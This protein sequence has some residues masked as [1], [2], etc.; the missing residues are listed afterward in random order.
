MKSIVKSIFAGGAMMA[1][2]TAS[3]VPVISINIDYSA[4]AEASFLGELHGPTVTENFDGWVTQGSGSQ[5][6]GGSSSQQ[7]HGSWVDSANSFSSNVGT[8]TVVQAG[9]L[10]L[11]YLPADDGMNLKIES[12]E[13]GEF[14]REVLSGGQGDF[15]LDS[16][17]ARKVTLTFDSEAILGGTFNAF[18]FYIADAADVGATLTLTFDDGSSSSQLVVPFQQVN[19]SMGY[20]TVA[21]TGSIVGGSITFNNSAD[22]D[23]WGIDNIT[24]GRLSEPGTL[25]LLGVGLLGLG[26]ARRRAAAR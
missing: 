14:G 18:G 24:V 10:G 19:A 4:G 8:F 12:A 17:D 23:G 6:M 16:N 13:T 11:D 7:Q 21:T 3:A 22:N 5:V 2:A 25:L 15:W 26:A 9:Q 1:A 20:V